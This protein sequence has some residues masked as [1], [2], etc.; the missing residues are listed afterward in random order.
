MPIHHRFDLA[1]WITRCPLE[2]LREQARQFVLRRRN[3]MPEEY[4]NEA[5]VD[6]HVE[7][8]QPSGEIVIGPE[9]LA[10]NE[11]LRSEAFADN[12]YRGARMATDMFVWQPGEPAHPAMTK[13][14]GIP[15]RS[16]SSAWP[17]DHAGKPI[18]FVAQLCF[19]DSRD[20]SGELPGDL[21]L[22]FGDDHALLAE[23]QR[24]VFEWSGLEIAEPTLEGPQMA[25]GE[26]LTPYHGVIHRTED[27]PDAT[28]E[29][30]EELL[31]VFEGTKIG[32]LPR[33]IQGEPTP[34]GRF[35]AALGSISASYS[36]AK[37]LNT[38][39]SGSLSN[40]NLMIGD[41]GSLYLFLDHQGQVRG[42]SQCY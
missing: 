3:D 40:G 38:L 33:F 23:P 9:S 19:A 25:A 15:Y 31:G 36:T 32:G 34:A 12:H 2:R 26:L 18:R 7:L 41:M 10:V 6:R 20:I 14:G 17:R 39:Q 13:V 4:P 24:L 22:I 8:M 29:L 27:W 42:E 30:L 21:L 35:I 11:Q 1:H 37:F 16:R 28:E 5:A